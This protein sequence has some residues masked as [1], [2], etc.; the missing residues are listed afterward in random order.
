MAAAA[1]H[2]YLR[3]KEGKMWKLC[4]A[5]LLCFTLRAGS[6]F[7]RCFSIRIT[8]ELLLETALV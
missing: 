5:T 3:T 7:G 6:A 1:R 8:K 2:A 4:P